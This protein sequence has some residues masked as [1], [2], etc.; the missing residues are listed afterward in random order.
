[1]LNTYLLGRIRIR[2][3]L[4]SQFRN[5]SFASITQATGCFPGL[6]KQ[7]KRNYLPPPSG[8]T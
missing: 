2:N 5:K 1:M 4:Q 8:Y 7:Q 6:I 3:L